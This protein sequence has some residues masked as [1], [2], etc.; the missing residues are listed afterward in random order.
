MPISHDDCRP[1]LSATLFRITTNTEI[2][3]GDLKKDIIAVLRASVLPKNEASSATRSFSTVGDPEELPGGLELTWLAYD[4]KRPPAWYARDDLK[5]TLHHLVVISSREDVLAI[6]FTDGAARQTVV[7][8]I[9]KD[10]KASFKHIKK[11]AATDVEAAFVE[12]KV[13]TLWLSGAHRRSLVKP[14]A[15]VLSG[16][17]LENALDP[18]EDQSYYFS[19]VRTTSSNT[20]LAQDGRNAIIGTSPKHARIWLGPCRDWNQFTDR[21]AKVLCQAKRSLDE[22]DKNYTPIPVLARPTADVGD[23]EHPYGVAIIVPEQLLAD[24]VEGGG[25]DRW[26]QQFADQVHFSVFEQEG[27]PD[28]LARV[29][30][31]DEQYGELSFKFEAKGGGVQ[32][33]SIEKLT[34]D[35]TKEHHEEI[36]EVCTDQENLTLYFDT[37]HTFA[38]GQFYLT[39]F[40]DAQFEDWRWVDM[41]AAGVSVKQEKPLDGKRFAVETTGDDEDTSLFGLIVKHWPNV[42]GMGDSTGWL[43]CDDGAGESADFIHL[44]DNPG[45]AKLTLIHAK[46]SGSENDSRQISVSE[47]EVVVGQAVKNLRHVDRGLLHEKLAAN[48]NGV[49]RDAVW[50]NGIRQADRSG[51]L[52]ALAD[53][54]SDL[55]LEVVVLQPRVRK[56]ELARARAEIEGGQETARI[57]RMQ[58]LDALLLGAKANCAA[59]GA[60]FRVYADDA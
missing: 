13:R 17:E 18:L 47:Y 60:S 10:D 50:Y 41:G 9:A 39:Q 4:E 24:V 3:L 19:S 6:C 33:L 20:E 32:K 8:A 38:R 34:W 55:E 59:L 37:G 52:G 36:L 56:A 2:L 46:G 14:D 22:G 11:M 5:N 21:L 31:G 26:F 53:V 12:D 57:R 35:E 15:K 16:A 28:F 40:R 23:V 43:V 29:M 7:R 30:W 45:S 58:Q 49:L 1:Y 51:F 44:D 48:G 54:G 25:D 27:T 42:E